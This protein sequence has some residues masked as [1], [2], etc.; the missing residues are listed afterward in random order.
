MKEVEATHS[1]TSRQEESCQSI[2]LWACCPSLRQVDSFILNSLSVQT[3]NNVW[4]SLSYL[5]C[6]RQTSTQGC[7]LGYIYV[8]IML[9]QHCCHVSVASFVRTYHIFCG[10]DV[11]QHWHFATWIG[12]TGGRQAAST[13][14]LSCLKWR[15]KG[16]MEKKRK[17]KQKQCSTLLFSL[18]CCVSTMV[19]LNP[20]SIIR[21]SLFHTFMSEWISPRKSK[22]P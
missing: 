17:E 14:Q 22:Q 5:D 13:V 12:Q 21:T 16:S 8:H 10:V 19:H 11:G 15:G 6:W 20:C 1:W 4:V 9:P 2:C 7:S 3:L 18:C